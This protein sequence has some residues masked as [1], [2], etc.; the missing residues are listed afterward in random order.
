MKNYHIHLLRHGLTAANAEGRYIG[1]TD[2]PLS[3]AGRQELTRLKQECEYPAVQRVYTSPL[4]RCTETAEL[5]YPDLEVKKVDALR[6]YDFGVFENRAILDL[7][8]DP[9][10]LNW[11]SQ[12]MT[13]P[14]EGAESRETFTLRYERGFQH[15]L[16]EMMADGITRAAVIT[17]AGIITGL[18][19]AHGVPQ[20]E[21]AME[22]AVESGCGYTVSTS[23]QLWSMGEIFEVFDKLPSSREP[24]ETVYC[25]YQMIDLPEDE[26]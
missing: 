23:S 18:L 2:L 19:A 14:P 22:W 26:E 13:A 6:E 10:F 1:S 25:G 5:L 3:E 8:N 20:R 7:R 24:D 21:N 15:I 11:L 17:H 12:G 9:A 16:R 4:K